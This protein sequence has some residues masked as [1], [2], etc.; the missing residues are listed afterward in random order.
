MNK[1]SYNFVKEESSNSQPTKEEELVKTAFLKSVTFSDRLDILIRI[2]AFLLQNS[3]VV[4]LTS[5][6]YFLI[7]LM[8][9][10][11]FEDRVCD[12]NVL[13]SLH[14]QVYFAVRVLQTQLDFL[15][16][17][18]KFTLRLL[19]ENARFKQFAETNFVSKLLKI[20]ESRTESKVARI[21]EGL[22]S[23]YFVCDTDNVNN[24]S[25]GLSFK[26][27]RKQRDLFYEILQTWENCHLLPNWNFQ[28]LLGEQIYTLINLHCDSSNF[29]HFAKLFKSQLITSVCT[30]STDQPIISIPNVDKRKLSQLHTRMA[31]VQNCGGLNSVPRFYGHEEFY[32]DFIMIANSYPFNKHLIDSIAA[33]MI[34]SHNF[35]LCAEEFDANRNTTK[36]MYLTSLKT[37][38][39]LAKFL[40]FLESLP[41][42]SNVSQLPEEV[43][44]CQLQIRNHI[45][46]TLDFKKILEEAVCKKQLM[47]IV[48]WLTEYLA[49]L[50]PVTFQLKQIQDVVNIL[51]Q[52]YYESYRYPIVIKLMIGWLLELPHFP[53]KSYYKWLLNP[54]VSG[55]KRETKCQICLDDL[56]IFDQN[57]FYMC[58]SYLDE[59]KKALSTDVNSSSKII[60][61]NHITPIS[62]DEASSETVNKRLQVQLEDA[63]FK[64]QSDS[65]KK[66]VEF[67][68]ER[69]A[70]NCVK[71]IC[72]ETVPSRKEYSL[73]EFIRKLE[74]VEVT[75]NAD[76]LMEEL[77]TSAFE[78]LKND[79]DIFISKE[80]E[81]RIRATMDGLL[82]SNVLKETKQLCITIACRLCIK[83]IQNWVEAHVY[84]E[85]FLKNFDSELRRFDP[86]T[87]TVKS[88]AVFSL[89]LF[90]KSATHNSD[91]FSGVQLMNMLR[92]CSCD[93][94]ENSVQITS[95]QI[96]TLVK[97]IRLSMEERCDLNECILLTLNR[98]LLDLLLLLISYRP[99]LAVELEYTNF[100]FI[101]Q[102]GHEI[103]NIFQNLISPR[104]MFLLMQSKDV[105]SSQKCFYDLIEMATKNDWVSLKEC[106]QQ[107]SATT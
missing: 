91:T 12:N 8:L 101:F 64:S 4:N 79:I 38:K 98:S 26:M 87:T 37:L 96:M 16:V 82:A 32:K 11:T 104:N 1:N 105:E 107:G 71:E 56:D 66:T 67:V 48:P 89:P 6:I 80:T 10:K 46:I 40:G 2:Y 41:Y 86:E 7:T 63:F 49:M 9:T 93:I 45:Q 24:F 20:Q 25:N 19:V 73:Q 85:I 90:G 59:I 81:T 61:L 100:C 78:N 39:T 13:S 72:Y 106:D 23:V 5:E 77:A 18:D 102:K 17:L 52:I 65:I 75:E 74:E 44:S 88:K 14:N 50:D 47:L 55:Y 53:N 54:N 97:S 43:I 69:I 57:V 27:F 99:C 68:A 28:K 30:D 62:A 70:S 35:S 33:E 22:K 36:K 58:C 21:S 103:E 60:T 34:T 42:K 3:L 95:T 31:G 51:F 29:M 15:N 84:K 76:N 94:L 92:E 83:R